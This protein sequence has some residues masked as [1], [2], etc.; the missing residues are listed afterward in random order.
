MKLPTVVGI[1][2]ACLLACASLACTDP[3]L[4]GSTPFSPD[5]ATVEIA[6]ISHGDGSTLPFPRVPLVGD[7][8]L[9]PCTGEK[10]LGRFVPGTGDERR[11]QEHQSA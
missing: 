7:G 5:G 8:I 6:A 4:G 10:A 2:G 1:A 9:P 3:G 11:Q